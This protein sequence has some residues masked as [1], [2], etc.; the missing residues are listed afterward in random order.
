MEIAPLLLASVI[1]FSHAFEADHL[2]AVS[3]IVTQRNNVLLALKD[4]VYWGLGHTSIILMVGC[5]FIVGQITLNQA[6][7]RYF[8]A[9]V[10]LMLVGMGGYRLYRLSEPPAVVHRHVPGTH[11]HKLAYGVGLVH[12]MA[13]SGALIL[14]MLST[15]K[16]AFGGILYLLIFGIGSI[17]GMMLAAGVF[18]IPFSE[19]VMKNKN[20][21]M[22][23]TVFSSLLCIGLGSWVIIKNIVD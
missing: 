4:G 18:S 13:G 17:F 1:G 8:E 16:G 12:G 7:F 23:L 10:G 6:V 22:S 21:R 14:S 3:S 15:A 5:V 11:P 20:V 2:V 19:K 9:T